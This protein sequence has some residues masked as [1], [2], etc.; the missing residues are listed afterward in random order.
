MKQYLCDK[1]HKVLVGKLYFKLEQTN[2]WSVV[3]NQ[4]FHMCEDCYGKFCAWL[5]DNKGE[6]K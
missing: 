3:P 5:K 1:C 4:K 6:E 2:H